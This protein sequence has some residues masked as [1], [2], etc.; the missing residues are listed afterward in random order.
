MKTLFSMLLLLFSTQVFANSICNDILITKESIGAM[1]V[2]QFNINKNLTIEDLYYALSNFIVVEKR[3][4]LATTRK[5]LKEI[6]DQL[7]AALNEPNLSDNVT[8]GLLEML[9]TVAILNRK[10][11]R[12]LAGETE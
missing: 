12:I 4:S 1:S 9:R 5:D 3:E 10:I 7:E 6:S 11:D 2:Q 8:K